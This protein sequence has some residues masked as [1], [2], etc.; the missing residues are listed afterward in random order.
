[1][2]LLCHELL[3][4]EGQLTPGSGHK[5]HIRLR[6]P[7]GWRGGDTRVRGGAS[8]MAPIYPCRC[9]T[10]ERARPSWDA[11]AARLPVHLSPWETEPLF[12]HLSSC[13]KQGLRW[14]GDACCSSHSTISAISLRA[15]LHVAVIWNVSYYTLWFKYRSASVMISGVRQK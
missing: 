7:G 3:R 10:G 14:L 5:E 2:V 11:A 8:Q 1:M 15:D 9:R 13:G 4:F 6:G 12:S